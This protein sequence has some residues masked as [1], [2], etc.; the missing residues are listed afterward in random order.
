VT[1]VIAFVFFVLNRIP[2]LANLGRKKRSNKNATMENF[3]Q[4]LS[5]LTIVHQK[6]END[7]GIYRFKSGAVDEE[8]EESHGS[9]GAGQ[10]DKK[11]AEKKKEKKES[12][13][14]KDKRDAEDGKER[15]EEVT[16]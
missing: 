2:F 7:M 8:E 6:T 14:E 10:A 15:V 3:M 9:A 1:V 4:E 16:Q 13:G 12:E 11:D 5:R